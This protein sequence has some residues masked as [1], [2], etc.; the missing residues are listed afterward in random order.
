MNIY[1]VYDIPYSTQLIPL[2]VIC[3]LLDKEFENS[4]IKEKIK[5]MVLV[6]SIWGTIWWCK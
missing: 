4:S 5:T 1:S 6:R 3:T 2:A